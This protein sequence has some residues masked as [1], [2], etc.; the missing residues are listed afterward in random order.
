[1]AITVQHSTTLPGSPW[2]FQFIEVW[3]CSNMPTT[4]SKRATI[5]VVDRTSHKKIKRNKEI[6]LLKWTEISGCLKWMEKDMV[7]FGNGRLECKVFLIGVIFGLKMQT[8][9]CV[10]TLKWCLCHFWL[11]FLSY[12]RKGREKVDVSSFQLGAEL[13]LD[14]RSAGSQLLKHRDV[15]SWPITAPRTLPLLCLFYYPLSVC[16]SLS[17]TF[18]AFRYPPLH[19]FLSPNSR[20]SPSI[21]QPCYYNFDFCSVTPQSPRSLAGRV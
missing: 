8:S 19:T 1:M 18:P 7:C 6:S 3:R 9:A 13:C 16:L 15:S 10:F 5:H 20:W 21:S 2:K 11:Q 12:Q 17:F 14:W 4:E